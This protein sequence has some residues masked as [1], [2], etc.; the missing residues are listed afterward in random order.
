MGKALTKNTTDDDDDDIGYILID[1][2]VGAYSPEEDII[3]W[4]D[5]LK[6][7]P[8]R[9]EVGNSIEE[10]KNLLNRKRNESS[11]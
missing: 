6:T 3:A 4:I 9:P 8:D 7:Y 11:D 2:P 5:E 1:S 10:A